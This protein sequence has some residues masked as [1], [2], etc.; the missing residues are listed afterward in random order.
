MFFDLGEEKIREGKRREENL[1]LLF[2]KNPSWTDEKK[3]KIFQE[4]RLLA[5]YFVSVKLTNPSEHEYR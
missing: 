3:L 1:Q 2:P 4:R 5:L